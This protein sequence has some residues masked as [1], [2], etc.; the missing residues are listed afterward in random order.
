[1]SFY[2]K[3][4]KKIKYKTVEI[5]Y[6]GAEIGNI[7]GPYLKIKKLQSFFPE[8]K[9]E[10]NI[11]YALSNAPKLTSWSINIIKKRNIPL[12]LNQNGIF[13]P[14]WY[15]GNW[16]NQNLRISKV[17]HCADYVFWQSKFC[18]KASD[19]FLG[20][21]VGK[22]EILYN[23]IDTKRFFPIKKN[24]SKTFKLLTTGNIRKQN[25]Y[26]IHSLLEAVKE[27][28]KSNKNVH[29]YIA[30]VIEDINYFKN[31]IESLKIEKFITFLGPYTQI[32]APLIYQKV[33]AYITMSYQDNCPSA[34]IEAMSSGLPILYSNSGGIPE[35]VGKNCG[36]GLKVDQ[37][38]KKIHVPKKE[39]IV[40]GF[41]K[42][43]E[44]RKSMSD[45]SRNR[46]VELFDFN[47]W[48]KRHDEVFDAFIN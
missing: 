44:N 48:I 20:Q 33:D 37:D 29:L 46:A 2:F 41:F 28:A 25:N 27:I 23:A 14:S 15:K 22:G 39:Q 8:N 24:T 36:I 4:Y 11:I 38:W 43:I 10:F 7:G 47:Y 19:I 13:Y 1:M 31:E 9:R 12:I 17:Y 40:E 34:V 30:G 18:K 45:S 3:K 16:E 21:R 42:I 5:Y 35:L 6:A 32:D 26:R